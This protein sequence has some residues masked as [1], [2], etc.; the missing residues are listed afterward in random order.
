MKIK[1]LLKKLIFKIKF[2]FAKIHIAIDER[3]IFNIH[4]NTWVAIKK[5]DD[6][7]YVIDNGFGKPPYKHNAADIV[8]WTDVQ[9]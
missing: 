2:R 7:F 4:F 6:R 5:I 8:K 1:Q 9:L 3:G